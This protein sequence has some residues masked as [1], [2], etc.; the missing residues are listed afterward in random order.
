MIDNTPFLH[1]KDLAEYIA[2]QFA[3]PVTPLHEI[4]KQEKISLFYDNYQSGT[5]D[6]ITVYD[7]DCFYMHLNMANGNREGSTRG[8]FTLAHELGHYFLDAHR[9]GLIAGILQPHPSM[10]NV[11]QF[12]LI[13]READYFASCLLMPESRFRGDVFKQKFSFVIID[14]LAKKYQVSKT[15]CAFRFA[16]IGNHPIMIVYAENGTIKWK[17]ESDDF[18]YKYLLNGKVVPANTVMGEYFQ[19]KNMQDTYQTEQVWAMDWFNYVHDRDVQRKFFEHC[20]PYHDK[21]L[22]IIWEK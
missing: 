8:R 19:K 9:A 14:A 10:V 5:F 12:N 21:A 20:I 3:D 11:G 16:E 1:I 15:A 7:N 17:M 2:L 22:S 4:V 13:E 18:P 6:G